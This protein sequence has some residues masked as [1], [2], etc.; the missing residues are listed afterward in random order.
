[1]V[2]QE[3]EQVSDAQIY[4][5]TLDKDELKKEIESVIAMPLDR[6]YLWEHCKFGPDVSI[7][8]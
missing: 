5:D 8:R 3:T 2:N 4:L 6:R 7:E 1:M